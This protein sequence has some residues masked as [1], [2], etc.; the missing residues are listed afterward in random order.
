M[1]KE[2]NILMVGLGIIGG[3]YARGLTKAGY[4][5]KAIDTDPA[6]IQ[7]ALENGIIAEGTTEAD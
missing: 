2:T 5:V 6:T 1:T 7:Y 4:T 3:S